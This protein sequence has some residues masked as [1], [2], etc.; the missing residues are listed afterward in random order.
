MEL[1]LSEIG[2]VMVSPDVNVPSRFEILIARAVDVALDV[3]QEVPPGEGLSNQ[4]WLAEGTLAMPSRE[5]SIF[6]RADMLWTPDMEQRYRYF[7]RDFLNHGMLQQ[8][9]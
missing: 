4:W 1:T 7:I 5:G 8:V 6:F 3:Q 9:S 2:R